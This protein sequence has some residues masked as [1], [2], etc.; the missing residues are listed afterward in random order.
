M[1]RFLALLSLCA[2]LPA[3][4]EF[5]SQLFHL[6]CRSQMEKVLK[7]A[8]SLDQWTKTVDPAPGVMSFRSPTNELGRWVE[9]QSHPSPY[10][11]VFEQKQ[12]KV[13]QFD[14]KDCKGLVVS[15]T[16]PLNVLN[17]KGAKITDA[18]VSKFT[19]NPNGTMVYVW[20][21]SMTYSMQEMG[22]FQKVAKE[23]N[24]TFVPVLDPQADFKVAEKMKK[25]Y[26]FDFELKK[27][28]SLE[29]HMREATIHFPTT[30]VMKGGHISKLI[31]GAMDAKTLKNTI[32]DELSKF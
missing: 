2:T 11:F 17:V 6:K 7:E 5:P 8:G 22:V 28:A 16:K 4:A 31:F 10:V 13:R 24:L 30:Y 21:P 9:V 20:S 29:L 32:N 19:K 14:G 26:K 3:W 1:K 18:D 27:A 25:I 23:M 15:Q 12:T